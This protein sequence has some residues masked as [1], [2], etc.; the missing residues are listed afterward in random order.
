[1]KSDDLRDHYIEQPH[2]F[3]SHILL[4]VPHCAE[5]SGGLKAVF[6][7]NTQSYFCKLIDLWDVSVMFID[8]IP[9]YVESQ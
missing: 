3:K 6:K 7:R 8:N 4:R 1:M 5:T 9:T 2:Q